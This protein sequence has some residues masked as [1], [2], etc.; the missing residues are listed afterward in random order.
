MRQVGTFFET[1]IC[2]SCSDSPEDNF[3]PFSEDLWASN[4]VF[5]RVSR[6]F[7]PPFFLFFSRGGRFF[8]SRDRGENRRSKHT[9][10]VNSVVGLIIRGTRPSHIPPTG[11]V[12]R[13]LCVFPR[14]K[15]ALYI[16]GC[17]VCVLTFVLYHWCCCCARIPLL[18]FFLLLLLSP[19]IPRFTSFFLFTPLSQSFC[20]PR[21]NGLIYY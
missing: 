1:T 5:L 3:S 15:P 11:S 9:R 8:I 12:S 21:S 17:P 6:P 19:Q 4:A 2:H 18:L 13:A 20:L 10:R 14:S 16:L 7:L